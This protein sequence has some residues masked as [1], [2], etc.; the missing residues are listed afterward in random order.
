MV[1]DDC[2]L[3]FP[4]DLGVESSLGGD[5]GG[6]ERGFDYSDLLFFFLFLFFV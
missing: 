3:G 6:E 2:R 4:N 5:E 1:M